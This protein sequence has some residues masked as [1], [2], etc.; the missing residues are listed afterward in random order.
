[1][2][3]LVYII[4]IWLQSSL[5]NPQTI[6]AKPQLGTILE[7]GHFIL[8]GILYV[9]IY[10]AWLTYGTMTWKKEVVIIVFTLLCALGDELHQYY[11]PYRSAS[12][13]D[14]VKNGVGILV[15]WFAIRIISKIRVKSNL[16]I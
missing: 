10:L 12:A 4:T 9:L 15:A 14:M 7:L 1:M 5:F 6:D 16:N 8:F 11:V 3:P 2:L 13:V